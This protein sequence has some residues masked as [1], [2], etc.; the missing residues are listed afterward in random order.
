MERVI[1]I[2]VIVG[3]A[4]VGIEAINGKL[5]L[6]IKVIVV[7]EVIVDGKSIYG[8]EAINSELI[9]GVAIV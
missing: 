6:S 7:G 2:R 5:I 9:V 3:G 1:G 4:I 8:I